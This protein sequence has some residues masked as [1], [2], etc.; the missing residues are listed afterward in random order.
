MPAMPR[1]RRRVAE[2]A[3][4]AERPD[5][6]RSPSC[7]APRAATSDRTRGSISGALTESGLPLLANDPHLGP[8]MPSI[9]TQ[10]GLHCAEVR[11]D[12]A[13]DV[14]G[15]HVLGAAG[16][17]HRP[18]R[19]HRL[20]VHEPR[21]RR[22]R[23]V[24]SSA[25]TATPTNSTA[26][27][28]RSRCARRPSTSPAATPSPSRCAPPH[29][30][31][32]SPTSATTS[33][34]SRPSTPRHPAQPERRLRGVAAVDG[35]HRRDDAA[36]RL[37]AEPRPRLARLPRRRLALRR[38]RAEPH[39][40]RRSTA[41]SATRRPATSPCALTGDG[42]VPLP[43]WTSANGWSG[44]IAVRRAARRCSIPPRATS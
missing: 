13:F 1:P 33:A 22:R 31:R 21:A 18:Q 30:A 4:V 11:D 44:S 29:A 16:R 10:M 5:R 43:G 41:T 3:G 42:T 14:C 28:C 36:G 9:W 34:T 35:A 6:R 7:S 19:P 24:T 40:R 26:R 39:L 25:S 32:S 37:R 38:A 17:H 27:R 23:P 12:C 8:A 2:A 15:L 20:G